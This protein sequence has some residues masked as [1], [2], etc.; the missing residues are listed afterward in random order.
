MKLTN[1]RACKRFSIFTFDLTLYIG[2]NVSLGLGGFQFLHPSTYKNITLIFRMHFQY[3][4]QLQ[5]GRT[6]IKRN[7]KATGK[8]LL[9][10]WLI[11]MGTVI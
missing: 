10:T 4:Y 1:S 5:E 3:F 7:K 6:D 11:M 9:C 2:L 8:V